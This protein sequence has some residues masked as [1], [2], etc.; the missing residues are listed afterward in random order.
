MHLLRL[1]QENHVANELSQRQHEALID[2]SK[3][4][5]DHLFCSLASHL[6]A[7]HLTQVVLVPD[8]LLAPLPLHLAGVCEQNV[9]EIVAAIRMAEPPDEVQFFAEAFPVEYVPCLQ[10]AMAARSRIVSRALSQVL[11]L[12]D[13]VSNSARG[14]RHR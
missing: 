5:H 10:A 11:A 6:A 7:L 8:L 3:E 9:T 4:L 13:P 12:S 2:I 14:A 1:W